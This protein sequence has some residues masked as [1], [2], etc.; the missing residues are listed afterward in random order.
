[1]N[2]R[3]NVPKGGEEPVKSRQAGSED[4]GLLFTTQDWMTDRRRNKYGETERSLGC[5]P[6]DIR[7]EKV[8]DIDTPNNP[9]RDKQI[10]GNNSDR[11]IE[12]GFGRTMVQ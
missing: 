7:L 12:T 2:E 3:A 6:N 5:A 4:K 9:T 11:D 8:N 1:M 10:R